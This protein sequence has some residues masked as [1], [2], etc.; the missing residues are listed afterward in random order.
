MVDSKLVITPSSDIGTFAIEVTC[1]DGIESASTGFKLTLTNT[2]PHVSIPDQATTGG[3]PLSF[4]LP[5]ID[6]DGHE[7][8]D[9]VELLGDEL[10]SLDTE[11]GFYTDGEFWTDY[12]DQNERWIRDSSHQWFY[13]LP[14]GELHQWNGSFDSS[15]LIAT[16]GTD[17]YEDPTRL[18]DPPVIPVRCSVADGL[19]S[20]VA[21]TD[22][23][24]TVRIRIT[25]SDG[26]T[27]TSTE[28][29]VA[30]S[31]SGNSDTDAVFANLAFY[32]S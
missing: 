32:E 15:R 9:T 14:N 30:V 22:Y 8:F 17:V 3:V 27:V 26:I 31:S 28:F 4:E 24:G 20:V 7:I 5:T 23:S 25:A 2:A 12:L 13:L 1:H 11:H 19:L 6:A 21:E 18:T 10:S 29:R 16:L